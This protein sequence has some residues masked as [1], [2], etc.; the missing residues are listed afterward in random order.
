[1]GYMSVTGVG[2]VHKDILFWLASQREGRRPWV[3]RKRSREARV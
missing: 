3:N 2:C 1:M